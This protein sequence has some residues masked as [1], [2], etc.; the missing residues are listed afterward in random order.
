MQQLTEQVQSVVV[1]A[2]KLFAEKDDEKVVDQ[3]TKIIN[4][5]NHAKNSASSKRRI[6]K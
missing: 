1:S 4:T 6:R 3:C 2:Q 5:L